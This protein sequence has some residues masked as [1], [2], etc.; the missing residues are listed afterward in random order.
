MGL[1]ALIL[2]TLTTE[3]TVGRELQ[4]SDRRDAG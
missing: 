2:N 3:H 1:G 4:A